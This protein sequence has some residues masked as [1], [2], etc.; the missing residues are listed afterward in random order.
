MGRN[1]E[2]MGGSVASW[3][4]MGRSVQPE[5]C[6][7]TDESHTGES[8]MGREEKDMPFPLQPSCSY[9]LS[10]FLSLL[11][12]LSL[13]LSHTHTHTH[14]HSLSPVQAPLLGLSLRHT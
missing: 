4:W 8:T 7:G 3:R 5:V 10:L 1:E 6:V 14:I 13:S 12:S 2:D 11:F 9:V